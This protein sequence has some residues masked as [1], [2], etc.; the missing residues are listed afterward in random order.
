MFKKFIVNHS[1]KFVS[2]LVAIFSIFLIY[3]LYHAPVSGF[4]EKLVYLLKEKGYIIL[5][6]WSVLE[7]EIGLIVGGLLCHSGDLNLLLAIFV[8]GIGAFS[9]DMVAFFV[10]RYNKPLVHKKLKGQRR[11][12]AL[13]H[14]LL[15][16]YGWP[17]IFIQRYL[18]GLRTIIPMS[19]ALTKYEAKKFAII[20][21][22]S[23]WIWA[24]LTLIPVWYFG[25]QIMVV[26]TW[27]REHW[28]LAIPLAASFVAG[29]FYFINTATKKTYEK[30]KQKKG[31]QNETNSK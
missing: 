9:G 31:V 11:K 21:L 16:K 24:S 26:V 4:E 14:I 23:G 25:E 15:K 10:G 28:Y 27:A 19:I 13:A 20:N 30:N 12:F 1:G 2:A 18:Y 17:I 22:I 6:A 7:G 8:A 5:F 3:N 29:F